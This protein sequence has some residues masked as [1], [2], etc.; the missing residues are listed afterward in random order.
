VTYTIP[1]NNLVVGKTY[2]IRGIGARTGTNNSGATVAASLG[3]V[4]LGSLTHAASAT[5]GGQFV[6]W[7]F[8]CATTGSTGTVYANGY[9]VYNNTSLATTSTTAVTGINTTGTLTLTLT[10][11]SG[12][13]SNTYYFTSAN[14]EAVN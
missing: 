1:A 9:Y 8:T 12:S 7:L 13:T 10:L 14:I 3:G 6:E 2:R 5:A 4:S 11:A